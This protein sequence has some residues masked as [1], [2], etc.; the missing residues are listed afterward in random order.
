MHPAPAPPFLPMV[1]VVAAACGNFI[2][3]FFERKDKFMSKYVNRMREVLT[4][5]NQEAIGISGAMAD[6]RE[7]YSKEYAFAE[8]DKLRGQLN[9]AAVNARSQIDSI[10]MEAQ[11][12]ARKWAALD[13]KEIDTA[14]L[15]LLKGDFVLSVP[16]LTALVMKYWDNG[17]MINAIDK[18]VKQHRIACYVPCLDDKLQ[19]YK[20][21]AQSAHSMI[22]SISES[23]G[24]SEDRI[25][26]WGVSGNV[27]ERLERA[28]YGI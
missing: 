15:S 2:D 20:I 10:H 17:T 12:A 3:N 8:L 27:S 7:R 21:L 14:D 28:L 18:Y 13:G 24:V 22:G 26:G 19:A 23:T 5:F 1:A 25:S 11:A 6:S 4:T 9:E 16:D